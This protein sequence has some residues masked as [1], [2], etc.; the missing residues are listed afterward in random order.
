MA[1][2]KDVTKE[3]PMSWLTWLLAVVLAISIAVPL[4]AGA[5][6]RYVF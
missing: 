5:L 1:A 4:A 6:L 3:V 2:R